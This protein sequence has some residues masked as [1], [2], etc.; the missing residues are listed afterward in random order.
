MVAQANKE[1]EM[2][3]DRIE[4]EIVIEAPRKS[5]GSS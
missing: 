3:S 1:V 2:V 4:Q 5:S